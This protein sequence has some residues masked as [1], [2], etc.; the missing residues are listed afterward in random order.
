M[1]NNKN[2]LSFWKN[3]RVLIT[4][5]TGF[6]GSWL[7]IYLKSLGAKVYGISLKPEDDPNL[8]KLASLNKKIISYYIDI[9]DYKR[10]SSKI[11]EINPQIVFHLAAQSLVSESYAN[12]RKTHETNILGTVNILESLKSYR[13]CKS[14]IIVTTD[15]VYKKSNKY[16]QEDDKLG[17]HDPYSGSKAAVEIVTES[18]DKSFFQHS[19]TSISTVRAGNVIGG[20]DWNRNRIIP[21]AIRAWSNEKTLIIRN[22]NHVRPWQHVLE[23][24]TG[25]IKL[26]YITYDRKSIKG[27]YNFGPNPDDEK[28]VIDLVKFSSKIFGNAK[29]K[30]TKRK[31]EFVETEI[32]RLNNVKAKKLLKHKP[33]WN[34]DKAINKTILWYKNYYL[35][36]NAFELC[37]AD[38][39]DYISKYKI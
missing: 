4:G 36:G 13:K 18:Y 28:K 11:S 3:K 5:H 1:V 38:I 30:L 32:L 14:V 29:F 34:T 23:S 35:G 31:N 24:L 9:R 19:N 33:I 15:K 25:Y 39:K 12:S 20:G 7:S 16:M 27:S 21:D 22:P 10:V 26:A 8:Y 6:K 37:M 2:F 17:G